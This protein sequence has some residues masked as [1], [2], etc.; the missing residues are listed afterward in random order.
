MSK[1][2]R[3]RCFWE[4]IFTQKRVYRDNNKFASKERKCFKIPCV[5]YK[6]TDIIYLTIQLKQRKNF[7]HLTYFAKNVIKSRKVVTL[8]RKMKAFCIQ[9]EQ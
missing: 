8:L 2:L 6:L 3:D 5:A 9:E 4:Q 7:D 1:Y